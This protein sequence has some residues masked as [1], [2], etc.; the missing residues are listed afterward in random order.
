MIV[1]ARRDGEVIYPRGAT[2]LKMGDHL[3]LMGP[4]ESVHQ[5]AR[6]CRGR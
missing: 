3:T 6:R 1:L 2:V 4:I 5:M